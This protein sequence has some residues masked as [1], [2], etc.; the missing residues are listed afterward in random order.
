MQ[1]QNDYV[2]TYFIRTQTNNNERGNKRST[3]VKMVLTAWHGQNTKMDDLLKT[4]SDEQLAAETA[5][6][7]NTG[8]YLFGHF[9]AVNDGLFKLLGIGKRMH[10]RTGRDLSPQPGQIR[11]QHTI[12]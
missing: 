2:A 9:I 7:R 11:F 12:H 1:W 3:Y 5:P 8:T 6:G 10:P 4:P